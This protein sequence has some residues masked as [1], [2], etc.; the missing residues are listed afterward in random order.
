VEAATFIM[1]KGITLEEYLTDY[2]TE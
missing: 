1:E 2:Y